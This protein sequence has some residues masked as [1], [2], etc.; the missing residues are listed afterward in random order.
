[1][2]DTEIEISVIDQGIGINKEEMPKI[3]ERFY[4]GGGFLEKTIP[5]F[6]IGLF[7][8]EDIIKRHGG[9]IGVESEPD[10]GSRFYFTL[11]LMPKFADNK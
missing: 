11:P 5:G 2:T 1:M 7:I 6:G 9:I 10:K 4:R 8:A 3:F